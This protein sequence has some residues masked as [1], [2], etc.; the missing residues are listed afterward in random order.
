MEKRKIIEDLANKW[1]A[2]YP[3]HFSS[4]ANPNIGNTNRNKFI[5]L[6]DKIYIKYRI[7]ETKIEEFK[8]ILTQANITVSQKI[9][10]KITEK[11]R[12]RCIK[13]G[14]YLFLYKNDVLE[15]MIFI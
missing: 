12:E 9:P 6:L 15:E 3:N 5:E 4:S 1:Q 2:M 13:S 10:P 7:N 14:C 8:N 11:T